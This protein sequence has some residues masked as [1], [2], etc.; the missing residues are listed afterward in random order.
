[1]SGGGVALLTP[2]CIRSYR[3]CVVALLARARPFES[4]PLRRSPASHSSPRSSPLASPP[5][6]RP[7][8][9]TLPLSCHP[10][11]TRLLPH[12]VVMSSAAPMA[13]TTALLS[14]SVLLN[15]ERVLQLP[16]LGGSVDVATVKMIIQAE[17]RRTA[18]DEGAAD[19]K[20]ASA[21]SRVSGTS[22]ICPRA[23]TDDPPCLPSSFSALL[24][25][26]NISSGSLVLLHKQR[27]LTDAQTLAGVGVASNEMLE[28]RTGGVM[29]PAAGQ[30][31]PAAAQAG[32]Q[33]Q[34]QRRP[35]HPLGP[36]TNRLG[37]PDSIL[38]DAG[39]A[40]EFLRS[41]PQLLFQIESQNPALYR[42]IMAA[43][44][45]PFAAA[46]KQ[47]TDNMSAEKAAE[48]ERIRLATADPMDPTVQ[49]KI[50]EEIRLK[51]VQENWLVDESR[52][53]EQLLSA[54]VSSCLTSLCSVC[55]LSLSASVLSLSSQGIRDGIQSRS[56]RS[57]FDALRAYECQRREASSVR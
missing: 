20:P 51:N 28:A 3:R 52:A 42:S 21:S 14:L 18:M 31:R 1:M 30:A 43:D 53:R 26:T 24:S 39:K 37:I 19:T 2:A 36:S 40:R 11:A 41:T 7:R 38:H 27:V 55:A 57:S 44:L 22:F 46:W 33:G 25:Q 10:P 6:Q 8:I 35:Q 34:Q 48:L 32:G 4:R 17:V 49:A 45:A 15:G 13:D 9:R 5:L 12:P 29:A 23:L 47:I 56:V 50:E 54:V 16:P